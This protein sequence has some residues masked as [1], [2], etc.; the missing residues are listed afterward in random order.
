[1][2]QTMDFNDAIN[3]PAPPPAD[4][5]GPAD[6]DIIVDPKKNKGWILHRKPFRQQDHLTGIR[7]DRHTCQFTILASQGE[8]QLLD[9]ITVVESLRKGLEGLKALTVLWADQNGEIFG[10]NELPLEVVP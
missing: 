10:I 4:S 6:L 1:M 8:P 9:R 2:V 7:Y 3:A 5:I